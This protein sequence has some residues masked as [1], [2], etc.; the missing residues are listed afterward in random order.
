LVSWAIDLPVGPSPERRLRTILEGVGDPVLLPQLIGPLDHLE[1]ARDAVAAAAGDSEALDAAL[2]ELESV[3]TQ[4]TGRH[5]YQHLGEVYA[6]RS[7]VYEDCRRQTEIE[8]GPEIRAQ[9]GPPLAWFCKAPAG[10]PM[11][12]RLASMTI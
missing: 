10:S 8:I 5:P 9:I 12:S 7:L 4:H 6:G 1:S 3:F 2:G 11:P